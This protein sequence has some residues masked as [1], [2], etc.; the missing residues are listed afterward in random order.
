MKKNG[1]QTS[2]I[3]T[4]SCHSG[5]RSSLAIFSLVQNWM[6]CRALFRSLALTL[7]I[8][9]FLTNQPTL[10]LAVD[11][12]EKKTDLSSVNWDTEEEEDSKEKEADKVENNLSTTSWEDEETDSEQDAKNAAADQKQKEEFV[13]IE[14]QERIVQIAGFGV[15]C[16]Y[17]FG[18]FLTAYFT[19]NRKLAVNYSPELLILLHA[20]WPLQWLLLP[21]FGQKVR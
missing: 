5:L 2:G 1:S 3:S 16:I 21:F 8:A 9:L 12:T 7:L 6:D 19:R 20:F 4:F 10:S 17:L 13:V 18:M 11:A 15:F 14:K